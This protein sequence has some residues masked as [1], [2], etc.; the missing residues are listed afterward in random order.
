MDIDISFLF[1]KPEGFT[2]SYLRIEPLAPLSMVASLPGSYYRSERIPTNYMIYGMIENVLGWHFS[3]EDRK[4]IRNDQKKAFKKLKVDFEDIKSDT[5]YM[6]LIHHHLKIK[7]CFIK[8]DVMVYTDLWTQHLKGQDERH[9]KGSRA[10]SHDWQL[11]KLLKKG[12]EGTLAL[13]EE[14]E[15]KSK[16][17]LTKL[18]E[19]YSSS[20]PAYYRSATIKRE[21]IVPLGMEKGV[22]I[23][24]YLFDMEVSAPLYGLLQKMI[25]Q[26]DTPTYLGTSEGWTELELLPL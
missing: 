25:A 19:V 26:L 15:A 22:E 6:P 4:K 12:M 9:I 2:K 21:F 13:K 7:P 1:E 3:L 8:P 18:Y 5:G 23:R 16:T 14:G 20:F 17:E 24:S 11:T 10:W